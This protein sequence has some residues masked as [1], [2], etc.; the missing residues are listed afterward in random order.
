[1][2]NPHWDAQRWPKFKRSDFECPCCGEFYDWP[3]FLD[4][5]QNARTLAS[6]PF[7]IN[8]G[9]RCALHNVRVGGAPLSQHLNLAADISVYRR[10]RQKILT[11]C[12]G[13]GF[14][15]FGFYQNMLHVDLGR[16]RF[17]YSGEKA[18]QK[19]QF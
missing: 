19:W 1:M 18:K 7:K 16:P 14:N 11:A 13:A 8:S 6:I 9:H 17:W 3:E 10:D 15:G 4:I 2:A 12:R 5:L